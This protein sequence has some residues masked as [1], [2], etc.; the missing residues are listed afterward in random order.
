MTGVALFRSSAVLVSVDSLVS[1]LTE[2]HRRSFLAATAAACGGTLLSSLGSAAQVDQ[3]RFDDRIRTSD[4]SLKLRGAAL[5]YYKLFIKVAAAG[6]YLDDRATSGDV[7]ADVAKRLEMQYFWSVKSKD[8]IKGTEVLLAR[9]LSPEKLA[10]VRPQIDAMSALYRDVR[11]GDRCSLT[12]VPGA[13]TTLALNG[14]TLG[15]VPSRDFAAAYFS[16]WFGDKPMDAGL[17]QKLLGG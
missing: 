2:L 3:V 8:L 11:A 16:I 13:G 12:Y 15:A 14:Q 17:K 4:V 1:E 9:N 6:L 5:F 7:L 10:A